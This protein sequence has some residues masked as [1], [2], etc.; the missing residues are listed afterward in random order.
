MEKFILIYDPLDNA[1][2]Q[3]DIP[4]FNEC[5]NSSLINLKEF[6]FKSPK[7]I[8]TLDIFKNLENNIINMPNLIK[9]YFIC[10]SIRGIKN[11][12]YIEFLEKM[13]RLKNLQEI[14]INIQKESEKYYS[15]NE[16]KNM[17]PK[18]NLSKFKK[19]NIKKWIQPKIID[20]IYSYFY[21]VLSFIYYLFAVIV[22]YCA[23]E[24]NK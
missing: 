24:C 7:K 17:F 5:F 6:I 19:I 20:K 18:V 4:I 23:N 14:I 13:F 15:L 11:G 21:N 12:L 10:N 16:L 1:N 3:I 22:Q 2:I 9:L 8:V